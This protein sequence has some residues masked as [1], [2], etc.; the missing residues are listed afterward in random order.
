VQLVPEASQVTLD[1]GCWLK[2]TV[3]PS[4]GPI[5]DE[6]PGFVPKLTVKATR[7][8]PFKVTVL[9]AGPVVGLMDVR[10]GGLCP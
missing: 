3:V 9:P 6:C 7:L 1:A 5:D 2:S 10:D 4:D 8:V